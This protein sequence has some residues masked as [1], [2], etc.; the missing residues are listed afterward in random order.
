MGKIEMK[1]KILCIMVCFVIVGKNLFGEEIACFDGIQ[2][3]DEIQT[4][5]GGPC[6]P[7]PG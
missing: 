4:D 1:I 5:C 7:C 6:D 2:N 3:Q